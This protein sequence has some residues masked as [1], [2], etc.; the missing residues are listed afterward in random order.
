MEKNAPEILDWIHDKSLNETLQTLADSNYI[1]NRVLQEVIDMTKTAD[2]PF[3]DVLSTM[4][5]V[6]ET[7]QRIANLVAERVIEDHV[8]V[9]P[10]PSVN[11]QTVKNPTSS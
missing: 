6:I 5:P 1:L 4:I 9:S 10:K 11:A 8:F 7:Q 2:F 3:R